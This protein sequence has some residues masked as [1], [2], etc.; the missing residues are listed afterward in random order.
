MLTI[1]YLPYHTIMLMKSSDRIELILSLLR[2]DR[3]II[4]DGRLNSKD[5]ATLIRETMSRITE[6]FHGIELGVLHD[7][8][9]RSIIYRAK[10][11]I[12]KML[13]G[14]SSGLTIIGPASVISEMRQYPEN[15][16]L[17]FD[18]GYLQKHHKSSH[19]NSDNKTTKKSGRLVR[20]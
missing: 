5:E 6:E 12:V 18:K 16:V 14:T 7:N 10:Q 11:G 17:H 1:H 2:T 9:R 4:I 20:D 13:T 3:I 19:A 8:A 15:V